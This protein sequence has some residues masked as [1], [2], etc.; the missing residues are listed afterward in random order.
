MAGATVGVAVGTGDAVVRESEGLAVDEGA[1]VG[2]VPDD[3]IADFWGEAHAA[4]RTAA[5][6]A[7]TAERIKSRP[8]TLTTRA[9]GSA[10]GW[11]TRLGAFEGLAGALGAAEPD[12]AG[13]P[14]PLPDG[15]ALGDAGH[16]RRRREADGDGRRARRRE[17]QHGRRRCR[18][19][20]V[21]GVGEDGGQDP[22][23]CGY[24]DQQGEQDDE[25][26]DHTRERTST[27]R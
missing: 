9:W 25:A 19:L 12:G 17:H 7:L 11:A 22:D 15:L 1:P 27:R 14:A 24:A 13:E 23:R 5:T 18:P 2:A 8:A 4:T 16:A 3:P 20:D 10:S 21:G 6:A 26:S